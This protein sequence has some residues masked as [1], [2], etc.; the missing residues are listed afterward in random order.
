[1]PETFVADFRTLPNILLVLNSNLF[2]VLKP[3]GYFL[4]MTVMNHNLWYSVFRNGSWVNFRVVGFFSRRCS[5]PNLLY[6][7]F[8][9]CICSKKPIDWNMKGTIVTI[10][11]F[12]MKHMEIITTSGPLEPIVTQPGTNS[13]IYYRRQRWDYRFKPSGMSHY[14]CT[15]LR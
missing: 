13:T 1:M 12:V 9:T 14:Q 5:S 10:E 8:G 4:F 2:S 11:M 7:F 3:L 15:N 6:V